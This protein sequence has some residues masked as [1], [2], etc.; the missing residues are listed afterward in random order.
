M[1]LRALRATPLGPG[2]LATT[3]GAVATAVG[4]AMLQVWVTPALGKVAI[5]LSS[6]PPALLVGEALGEPGDDKGRTFLVVRAVK[7]ILARSSALLRARPEDAAIVVNALFTAFNPTYTPQGVDE[8]KVAELAGRLQQVLPRN[9]DPTVGVLALEAA[10]LLGTQSAAIGSLVTAWAN[11]VALLAV[12]DP[13]AALDAIAWARGEKK[14][15]TGS[16]ERGS[17]VAR[18][19]EA[20]ELMTFSVTDPYSEAR[21]RLGVT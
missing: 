13:S 9:L 21:A 16:E 17:W 8:R 7:M 12:G 20:R 5:P 11:R 1:D 14:A 18:T 6:N 15:P 3:V 4:L 2:P 10:G 19:A